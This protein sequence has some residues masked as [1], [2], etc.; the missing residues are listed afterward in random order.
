M[1]IYS[2][3]DPDRIKYLWSKLRQSVRS[4]IVFK[5]MGSDIKMFGANETVEIHFKS[6]PKN[7]LYPNSKIKKTWNSVLLLCVGISGVF[8]PYHVCFFSRNS[9]WKWI[10]FIQDL[11]YV[12]D[13]CISFISAY[14][15]HDHTLVTSKRQIATNYLKSWF[16]LDF[17]S[18]LPYQFLEYPYSMF[19]LLSLLKLFKLQNSGLKFPQIFILSSNN[20]TE[21]LIKIFSTIVVI[22]QVLACF[23][24]L[25]AFFNDYSEDCWLVYYK[26]QD[27]D[28]G[29]IYLTSIY[30]VFVTITT[31]G[32]GDITPKNS[33][34]QVYAMLVMGIGVA[35]YSLTIGNLTTLIANMDQ[36]TQLLSSKLSTLSDLSREYNI[37]G[38]TYEKIRQTLIKNSNE[39][40]SL[41]NETNI[42]SE[43]PSTLRSEVSLYLHKALIEK[44]KFFHERNASFLSFV[45]P[46]LKHMSCGANEYLYHIDDEAFESIEYL[47]FFIKYGRVLLKAMNGGIFRAYPTGSYFGEIELLDDTNRTS[48]AQVSTKPAELLTLSKKNLETIFFEFPEIKLEFS[49]LAKIRKKL[50]NEAMEHVLH[51]EVSDSQNNSAS[52]ESE[53]EPEQEQEQE[54]IIKPPDWLLRRD[55]GVFVSHMTVSPKKVKNLSKWSKAVKNSQRTRSMM[56]NQNAQML[57]ER[58]RSMRKQASLKYLKSKKNKL[59]RIKKAMK[60]VE[61]DKRQL[62]NIQ[63]SEIFDSFDEDN[64]FDQQIKTKG[65]FSAVVEMDEII[66]D[67]TEEV[68]FILKKIEHVEKGIIDD[69]KRLQEFIN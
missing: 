3:P 59:Q 50:N 21:R 24:Y 44:I 1:K 7:L 10:K 69:F 39:N 2:Y 25:L 66:G 31:V 55:T 46:K 12:A 63:E 17:L 32:F 14:M 65:I 36:K 16:F 8:M 42:I 9:T 53:S 15:Y 62:I 45:V 22:V 28:N 29:F 34:E 33:I 51:L 4:Y 5:R 43:L 23:W 41:Y 37:P 57:I 47:V 38:K 64:K 13:I 11:I 60:F 19:S 58:Q 20:S 30:W 56:L 52:S 35:F 54:A 26:Y 48:A 68:N 67:R 40:L 61:D 6:N 49:D 27:K 18:C